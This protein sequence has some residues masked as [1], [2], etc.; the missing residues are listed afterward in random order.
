MIYQPTPV[1]SFLASPPTEN[2]LRRSM[3]FNKTK[4]SFL[5]PRV[6]LKRDRF[7]F[8]PLLEKFNMPHFLRGAF[9]L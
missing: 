6:Y 8:C 9:I 5:F 3:L 4:D 1:A 2:T 7:A